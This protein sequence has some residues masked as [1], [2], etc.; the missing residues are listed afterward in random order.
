MS[1]AIE[2][3]QRFV[4]ECEAAGLQWPAVLVECETFLAIMVAFT[5]KTSRTQN[6]ERFAQEMIDTITERAHVRAVEALRK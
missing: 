4:Q 6:P 5:A 2:T 3:A 1:I